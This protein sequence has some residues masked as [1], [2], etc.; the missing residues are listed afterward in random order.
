[1][2]IKDF[3]EKLEHALEIEDE[4]LTENTNVKE[5]DEYDS[6]SL[7]SIIAMIDESFKKKLSSEEFKSITTVKSLMLM[8]GEENFE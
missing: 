8:I 5:L 6:L 4:H 2:T 1:M 7:L 3:I